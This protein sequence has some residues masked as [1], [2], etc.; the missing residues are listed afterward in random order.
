MRAKITRVIDP[1]QV[2]D[3]YNFVTGSHMFP[4]IVAVYDVMRKS[5]KSVRLP[6]ESTDAVILSE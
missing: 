1:S 3:R 6:Y 2:N 5:A 4:R